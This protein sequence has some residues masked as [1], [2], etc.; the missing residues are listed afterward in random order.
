M[1]PRY[2]EKKLDAIV[3]DAL[4]LPTEEQSAY[5]TRVCAGDDELQKRALR[6][7][8]GMHASIP[9][10]FLND[11][12]PLS[13]FEDFYHEFIPPEIKPGD[14]IGVYQIMKMI[15]KG[16][17]GEV[18]LAERADGQVDRRVAIKVVRGGIGSEEAL[19]RFK[20]ERQILA[21]LT[22][23]NIATMYD[24]GITEQG[25]PY[26]AME[27]IEGLP[28]DKYC[29]ENEM[30]ISARLS[31]F[32]IVCAAVQYAQN[33]LVVHRDLK[34][35]NILVTQEG[36]VKLLDFGIAKLV[37]SDSLLPKTLSDEEET[38]NGTPIPL[39]DR[40]LT[41]YRAPFTPAYAA[42]EQIDGS[43]VNT[44][45]DVYSL[46][47][48]L[49][50]LLTGSRPYSLKDAESVTQ[51]SKIVKDTKPSIPSEQFHSTTTI[52]E[53]SRQSLIV[54]QRG[55][56]NRRTLKSML[57]GDLDAIV[58]KALEKQQ[59]NRYASA[60]ELATDIQRY[61][62]RRPVQARP[63]SI[64]IHIGR[65]AQRHKTT[66]I[67]ALIGVGVLIGGILSTLRESNLREAQEQS[68]NAT[69]SMFQ[70][71]L[72]L[73]DLEDPDGYTFTAGQ[74]IGVGLAELED[75][76]EYPIIQAELLNEFGKM[77]LNARMNNL[78]D[79][80]HRR[81]IDIQ[82]KALGPS[83]PDLSESYMRLA[84]VFERDG[85]FAEAEIHFL[86][87]LTLNPKNAKAHNNIGA[88][89]LGQ[90]RFSDAINHFR[91]AIE[92]DPDLVIALQNLSATYF[93]L[94]QWDEAKAIL[95]QTLEK[96]PHY[97]AF[98]N[99][100]TIHYYI[101]RDYNKAADF[102]GKALALKEKDFWSWS[103]LGAALY[104]SDQ[105][106]DSTQSVLQKAISL[107]NEHLATVDSTDPAIHAEL[108]TLH[109]LADDKI[110]AKYHANAIPADFKDDSTIMYKLGYMHEIFG[111]R[112]K[113]IHY[114]KQAIEQGYYLVYVENE[115]LLQDLLQD[116]SLLNT[117]N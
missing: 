28:I 35:S 4:D 9:G 73:V 101:D 77:S 27:Y 51:L 59:A 85:D 57:R 115:P 48:I 95:N 25:S 102:Y 38:T 32:K 86:K 47:V 26:L 24:V 33:N 90:G 83:H 109:A 12:L 78:A 19:E 117:L 50:E 97:N 6:L 112:E 71:I 67:A 10:H 110:R 16:G 46:G 98:S 29:D 107:A 76:A 36:N 79:S 39:P 23:P 116:S 66:V 34:P 43:Q 11:P 68:K 21:N 84:E 22:H 70:N 63:D 15:G 62:D 41:N 14:R 8:E 108:A 64:G 91:T 56:P 114:I 74:I 58:A 54:K 49:Y 104:W 1:E 94:E 17:M 72:N 42:P 60:G 75:W 37:E 44:A 113:A 105:H 45:T 2:T 31:F 82:T 13:S 100:A 80:L 30:S 7:I 93:Y 103:Y 20:Y 61:L 40:E 89:Y 65:F 88:F 92:L 53:N 69:L 3:A 96:V 99:L 111:E 106:K 81:A 52:D 87:S 55:A 5:L 18:Y